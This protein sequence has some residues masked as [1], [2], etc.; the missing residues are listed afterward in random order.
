MD[1][2]GS[3]Y[4]LVAGVSKDGTG[5]PGTGKA[6]EFLISWTTSDTCF[7]MSLCRDLRNVFPNYGRFLLKRPVCVYIYVYK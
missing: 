3:D 1:S 2:F 5:T 4:S 7:F 6:R